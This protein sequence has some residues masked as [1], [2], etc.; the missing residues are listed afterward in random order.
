MSRI[1]SCL[2]LILDLM[3]LTLASER[4]N[5]QVQ[6]ITYSEPERE[7][8]RRTNFEII[9]KI[10]GNYLVFKNNNANNAVSI[11]D[12]DMKLKQRVPLSFMPE[13]YINVDFVA[14]PEYCYII[15]EYQRRN[16]VHCTAVK[17]N[18]QGQKIGEPIELDT[19]Q[20]GLAS[21][22]KIYTTV[23][24]EDK[25]RIMVFKINSRN[26]HS[27]LF[28]TFLYDPQLTVLDRHRLY[29]PMEERNDLFTDFLLDN[30]GEMIFGRYQRSGSNDYITRVAIVTKGPTADS[31]SIKDIGSGDRIL[32]EI[33][34]KVDNHNNRYILSGFY[35]KQRRGNIEGLY[36]V[37]WDKATDAKVEENTSVFTE[38]LRQQAKSSDD[39]VRMAF[40]DFFIKHII[41]KRDGGYLLV[42]E[43]LYTTS[44]GNMFNRW[45]YMYN[46]AFGPGGFYSPYYYSPYY[47]PWGRNYGN[48]ATRFHA[49]NIMVLSFD[50]E[51]NLQWSSV[52]PKSQFD[53]ETE[54]LIS[55]ELVNTGGELHFLFNLYERRN[56]LLNDQ[57]ISPEGRVTRYPTLRNLDRGYDFMPRYGKQVSGY[58][59]IIPCLYR[60]YLCFAKVDF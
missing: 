25:Q 8:G 29:L 20:V 7:D 23:V 44:R 11:Y 54:N 59:S 32:D 28:T 6:Q 9:G 41:T 16:V 51:S 15:Y 40:N 30:E 38:E 27:F 2:L 19:T 3:T 37:I 58:E 1:L 52:I 14:Y 42:T 43:A 39:N 36:T 46:P 21:N 10:D 24:S 22:N 31:F 33:K 50:R 35:Y 34:I 55:H 48:Y 57:S 53:D 56:M 49:E 18:G 4:T 45:D 13:R 5:A 60:N 26:P 12:S 47:N 17:L